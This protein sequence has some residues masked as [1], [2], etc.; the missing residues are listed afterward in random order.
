MKSSCKDSILQNFL[1]AIPILCLAITLNSCNWHCD[2]S[3]NKELPKPATDGAYSIT[4]TEAQL[5]GMVSLEGNSTKAYYEYG[6]G[7]SYGNVSGSITSDAGIHQN[8]PVPIKVT[9]LNPGTT[10]HYRLVATNK[11]GT[12][13]GSD[14]TFTTLN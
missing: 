13:S 2:A 12:A 7:L 6:T 5:T 11:N 1:T 3:G 14:Q 10:Y 4:Q 9:G 8:W